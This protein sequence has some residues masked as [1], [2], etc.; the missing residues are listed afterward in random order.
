MAK[1]GIAILFLFLGLFSIGA[2]ATLWESNFNLRDSRLSDLMTCSEGDD[3]WEKLL[4]LLNHDYSTFD[5]QS[6]LQL[7]SSMTKSNHGT[8]IFYQGF[9]TPVSVVA[10]HGLYGDSTQFLQELRE[11]KKYG[12]NSISV[13]LPG[14]GALSKDHETVHFED[15]LKE[16]HAAFLLAKSL[17]EKVVIM[18]QSTGGLLATY[19][20]LLE[21]ESV[22][23]LILVEPAFRVLPHLQ[24]AT[25]A[26]KEISDNAQDFGFIAR[27][28]RPEIDHVGPASLNMGCQVSRLGKYVVDQYSSPV[29]FNDFQYGVDYEMARYKQVFEKIKMPVLLS[30]TGTDDVVDSDLINY[31][32]KVARQNT[33]LTFFDISELRKKEVKHGRG[34]QST[35]TAGGEAGHPLYLFIRETLNLLNHM[36]DVDRTQSALTKYIKTLDNLDDLPVAIVYAKN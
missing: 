13:T 23:G 33:K 28:I 6:Q 29:N 17:G 19:L 11:I 1:I 27:L 3:C 8:M 4:P 14:H 21:P 36:Q 22:G 24:W 12:I 7:V 15:W 10:I 34:S 20:A 31:F 16:V 18:G 30:Y 32:V 9:K 26:G 25:C 5:P 35:L 2:Q